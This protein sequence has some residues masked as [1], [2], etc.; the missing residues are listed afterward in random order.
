MDD[1]T[2][3]RSQVLLTHTYAKIQASLNEIK[4]KHP[5]RK[6]LIDSMEETLS[7]LQEVKTY[8]NQLEQEFRAVRQTAYRMELINL[9]L[10][11][12]NEKLKNEL[13]THEF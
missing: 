6:D 1:F 13:K 8:I 11:I 10:K 5:T 9:D 2:I 4:T 7:E 12:E 3:I